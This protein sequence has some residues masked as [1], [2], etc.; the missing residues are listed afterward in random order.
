M[1]QIRGGGREYSKVARCASHW[2]LRPS[3][4]LRGS[5]REVGSRGVGEPRRERDAGAPRERDLLKKEKNEF[6]LNP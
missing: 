1:N 5:R 4:S 2:S 3:A 6:L